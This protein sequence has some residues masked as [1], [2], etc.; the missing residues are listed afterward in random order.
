[1]QK[2]EKIKVLCQLGSFFDS[3]CN[4]H[5]E[6]KDN[7]FYNKLDLA[8]NDAIASNPY[9]EKQNIIY[10]LNY[11]AKILKENIL[12]SFSSKISENKKIKSIGIIMAGNI[13]LVGFHD[14]L[15]VFLSGNKS[16]IKL[17]K[18]D[19]HLFTFIY[20]FLKEHS[21]DIKEYVEINDSILQDYDAVIATGNDLSANQFKKYFDKVPNIIRNSR[22]SVGLLNGDESDHDLKKLSFDIF[23]YY[24]LGCRSVSK[25]YLP[26][27]YDINL[28]INSLNDWKDVINNS[29][30]YNNYTYNKTIYLMK[31]ERFFDTGFCIIKESNLIGS[32]IATIYY[33]YYQNKE[34]LQKKLIANQNKI[35]CIVSNKIVENSIEFGSTQ[36]PSIDDYADKINTID[37]LLKLS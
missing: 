11:W 6:I 4:N 20:S 29:T 30:Y 24:G 17:S 16:D 8:I 3:Y 7:K 21:S 32:P 36:S 27:G 22:F 15:C 18:K 34:E 1:M 23:M 13:P 26:K 12:E 37:F 2:N 33:E 19:S 9:F 28:I 31:G 10:N 5:A 35:Q 14:F 25:L